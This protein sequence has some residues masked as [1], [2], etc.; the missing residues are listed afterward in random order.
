M[1][2]VILISPPYVD[3]YGRLNKAAGRYFPLGLG[4]I[5][6]YLR[7]Y[8]N[9]EV[10]LY[11]PE[12]QGLSYQ[13]LAKIIKDNSPDVIGLTC[14]TP[15]FFRAIELAQIARKNSNA[16]IVLGGVH[17]SALPEFIIETYSDLIDCLVRGEGEI[18]ML[19]LIKA[20]QKNSGLEAIKGIVYKKDNKIIANEPRPF[21]EDLDSVPFPARDLIPQKLF[22]PN[23]HNSRYKNCLS[24]LTSRGCPFNCS[25]CAARIISGRKYRMH[26]VDYVLEEM[27]MLKKDYNAQQLLIT[28]DTFTINHERL[29]EICRGMIK[30]GLGLKWFC[31]AQVNTVNKEI[32]KLM[33]QAGCYN[34]GFG[35]ESADEEILKKM[36]KPIKPEQALKTIRTANEIGLKTQAFYIFGTPGETKEQM[37]RTI[38]FAKRVNSTLVFFNMLVPYPGTREFQYFF[39]SIPLNKIEWKNFVAVGENCVLKNSDISPEKIEKLMARAYLQYYLSPFRIANLLF[40]IRTFYE[41]SNYLQGGL[42]LL[43]QITKWFNKKA[44]LQQ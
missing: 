18:T 1:A 36:G 41:F 38:K 43:K 28:D 17:A 9:H 11:E 30:K 3:L 25:F 44:K 12:A 26:S 31:F 27:E 21:I 13:D 39:S 35:V 10:Q 24:I 14:S 19:E 5:A 20:Y 34:I 29:E 32:L 4:Y 2:K 23:L 7:K 15:N 33:K 37:E 22:W 40:Q 16:K 8:G 6:A 42:S